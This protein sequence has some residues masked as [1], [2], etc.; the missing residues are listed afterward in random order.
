MA[1]TQQ[2]PGAQDAPLVAV[3]RAPPTDTATEG[4]ARSGALGTSSRRGADVLG[5]RPTG[6]EL[7]WAHISLGTSATKGVRFPCATHTTGPASPR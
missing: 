2:V 3:G 6:T 5:D 1:F 4:L 7:A